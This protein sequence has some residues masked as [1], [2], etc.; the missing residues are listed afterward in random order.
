M[1][2]L[3]RPKGLVNRDENSC[4]DTEFEV[5][6][7]E[8]D[9]IEVN[10]ETFEEY[11]LLSDDAKDEK[12]FSDGD[13]TVDDVE[14]AVLAYSL[15]TDDEKGFWGD[16]DSDTDEHSEEDNDPECVSDRWDCL[17]CGLKNKPFVRYCG[18]CWQLRK[19]WLPD[20]PKKRK[21]KPRP[22]KR[23]HKKG[24]ASG[25]Q[26]SSQVMSS[27]EDHKT[28]PASEDSAD[29]SSRGSGLMRSVSTTASSSCTQDS[30][31]SLSQDLLES[32]D[33]QEEL[34]KESC[35]VER[36]LSQASTSKE[37]SQAEK[38]ALEDTEQPKIE[39]RKRKASVTDAMTSKRSKSMNDKDEVPSGDAETLAK[40]MFNFMGS[41]AGKMWLNSSDG[42]KFTRSL[43]FSPVYQASLTKM[44]E[45]Q[46]SAST[47]G[48]AFGISVLCSICCL[49]PKNASI[50]HGRIAHQATCYQCARRLLNDRASCPVCRR[51]IHMVC[52]QIIA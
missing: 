4:R 42:A 6:E 26:P 12:E 30:G 44:I 5:S 16:D 50:I 31:I 36:S 46:I 20:R 2:K 27:S 18:K 33:L 51:K 38:Q 52:K 23:S 37:P 45:E 14:I 24:M 34:A 28:A 25:E 43:Q 13:S 19:N 49:R 3:G 15:L 9:L 22:K 1:K 21:R 17:T 11:E 48:S 39:S 8:E 40:E 47:P 32:Q 29:D 7:E 35:D 41:S 10:S